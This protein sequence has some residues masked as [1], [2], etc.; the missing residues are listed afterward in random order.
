MATACGRPTGCSR[1]RGAHA[2]PAMTPLSV[3]LWPP[4]D[5][6]AAA[7]TRTHPSAER[8]RQLWGSWHRESPAETEP[9]G[10]A[11]HPLGAEG[12]GTGTA[13]AQR[14]EQDGR[15]SWDRPHRTPEEP[16]HLPATELSLTA[17]GGAPFAPVAAPQPARLT[18][19]QTALP[20]GRAAASPARGR[21]V[22]GRSDAGLSG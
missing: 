17:R 14:A 4:R 13:R 16:F 21:C 11:G 18:H 2:D 1:A 10:P 8:A 12:T 20:A 22:P 9:A 6:P 5:L 19:R 15:G 3:P 7:L